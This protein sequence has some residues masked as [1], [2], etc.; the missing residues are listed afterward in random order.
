MVPGGADVICPWCEELS[1]VQEWDSETQGE[2]VSREMKRAY[3]HLSDESVWG[4]SSAHFYKCPKCGNWSRGN[5][6]KLV[7]MTNPRLKHL[8]GL[9]ILKIK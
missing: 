7:G 4:K 8:G 5:Q 1:T 6:L 2:C 3:R 9:P